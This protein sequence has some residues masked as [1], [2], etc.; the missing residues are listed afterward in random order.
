MS[1]PAGCC[2][3]GGRRLAPVRSPEANGELLAVGVAR[4]TPASTLERSRRSTVIDTQGTHRRHRWRSVRR[5]LVTCWPRQASM[6]RPGSGTAW[7]T[8][9]TRRVLPG[10]F[11]EDDSRLAF[12]TGGKIGVWDVAVASECRTL[13]PA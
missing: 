1:K 9:A 7:E 4:A 5:S 11:A 2:S 10:S 13:H 6:A 12:S 3:I 8:L